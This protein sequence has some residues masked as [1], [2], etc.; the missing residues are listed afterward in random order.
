VQRRR[1][2]ATDVFFAKLTR[3]KTV[4]A[5]KLIRAKTVSLRAREGAS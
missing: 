5:R 1:P 2:S 3:A 4:S